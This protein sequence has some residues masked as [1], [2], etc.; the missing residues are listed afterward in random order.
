MHYRIRGRVVKSENAAKSVRQP[1]RR[2][3]QWIRSLPSSYRVLDFGCGKLRYTIPLSERVRSVL[4]VDSEQ[5]IRRPQRIDDVATTIPEYVRTHLPNVTACVVSESKWTRHR[6]DAA[7]CANVLSA[8]PSRKTRLDVLSA[9]GG[10]LKKR[11]TLLVCTQFRNSYFSACARDPKAVR[12]ND[13]WLIDGRRGVAFYAILPLE[14]LIKMCAKAGL[15]V[16]EARVKGQSAFV[17]AG[18]R[19]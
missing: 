1:C 16:K 5:Q 7:L 9:I 19:R 18:K 4:A 10:V 3:I 2:V 14:K 17:F 15:V 8:I 11:G 6:Y 13:G 12:C